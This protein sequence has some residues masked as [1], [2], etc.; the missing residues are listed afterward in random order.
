MEQV[1]GRAAA[2]GTQ[3]RC[4]HARVDRPGGLVSPSRRRSPAPAPPS[5]RRY[6]CSRVVQLTTTHLRGRRRPRR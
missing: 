2:A 3:A 5:S 4:L 1:E 6:T